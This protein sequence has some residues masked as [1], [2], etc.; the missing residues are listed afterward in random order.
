M[1]PPTRIDMQEATRLTR[2]GRLQD[3]MAVLQGRRQPAR[4]DSPA[5]AQA[6]VDQAQTP[7]DMQPPTPGSDGAWTAAPTA[8]AAKPPAPSPARPAAA[9]GLAASSLLARLRSMPLAGAPRPGQAAEPTVPEGAR[10]ERRS[11]GPPGASREYRLYVPASIASGATPARVPLVVM[12]HGCTQSPED[13]AVGTGMNRLAEQQGFV[14]AYPAQSS[15]A[16]S[17]RCWNWFNAADQQRDRGEPAL[18][19]GITRE[20]MQA[21]PVDPARVYVAGLS[22]GGAAAAI[23]AR[24][25]PDLYAAAGV[26]SGL[27]CGAASDVGSAFAA[28]RHGGTGKPPATTTA[29]FPTIVFHG[30]KDRTVHPVNG[31]QVLQQARGGQRLAAQSSRGRASGGG[32]Y[33]RTVEV[34]AQGR[35][36]LEHWLLHGA[37]HAWSGGDA[38]GSYTD[39]SGPDASAE[40]LRFFNQHAL[41]SAAAA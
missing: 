2:E 40:M 1:T 14:V 5:P 32:E 7:I 4:H 29:L 17:S 9:G 8:S 12:L 30:D 34:D 31:E 20:I 22:A 41:A 26:H 6:G 13:F 33:S 36:L 38:A 15:A 16:N 21:F 18:I 19:A 25:Y 11:F 35:P 28:M 3:A 27:A 24:T 39:A 10:F 37:G 23:L